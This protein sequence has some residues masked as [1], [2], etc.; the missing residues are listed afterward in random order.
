MKIIYLKC[1]RYICWILED[2]HDLFTND[3]TY[4]PSA[5]YEDALLIEEAKQHIRDL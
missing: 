1:M 2:F 5:K 4:Y 3:Y